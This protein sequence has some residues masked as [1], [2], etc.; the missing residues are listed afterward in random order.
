MKV[1]FTAH[2]KELTNRLLTSGDNLT[3]LTIEADNLNLKTQQEINTVR[4][5][6]ANKYKQCIV[7]LSDEYKDD[8]V[9]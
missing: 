5:S 4:D 9:T 3:R 8:D 2:I 7:I 1:I 6:E